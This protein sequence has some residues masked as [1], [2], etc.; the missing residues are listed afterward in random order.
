[1]ANYTIDILPAL[2]DNYIFILQ[3]HVNNLTLCIDPG[4]ASVVINFLEQKQLKLDYVLNT[5]HH[6]DHITGNQELL[7][8]YNCKILANS[9][10]FYRIDSVTDEL[11][12]GQ[13]LQLGIFNFKILATPGN[14]INHIS[15][16]DENLKLLFSGDTI[17]SSG[18]GRIIEGNHEMLYDSLDKL[19]KLD[20]ETLIYFAHEYTKNNIE[21]ALLFEPNN[22][23]LIDKYEKTKEQYASNLPTVPT[24][25]G[26]ELKTNPFL[27]LHNK[28]IRKNLGFNSDHLSFKVLKKLRTLKD[29]Y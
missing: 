8:K 28:E 17:F 27:R 14:A 3:D 24:T 29:K 4:D 11:T 5:H 9:K 25:L 2:S 7:E 23:D 12:E 15:Y 21:F 22:Q 13:I 1:M 16:H 6:Y 19:S 18:C 10:D 26:N 20:E